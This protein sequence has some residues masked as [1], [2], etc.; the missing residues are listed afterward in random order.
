M[1]KHFQKQI[2][3]NTFFCFSPPV[4]AAT[5]IIELALLCWSLVRYRKST[6]L[7]LSVI[8][9]L[10]LA[11]FQAAEYG[12]CESISLGSSMWAKIGF[13]SITVLPVAGLHLI[14]SIAG[15][16]PK[17][18]IWFA[19]LSGLI[20][21]GLFLFGG[22]MESQVCSGNYIIFN[23]KITFGGAY[24]MYYYFWLLFGSSVALKIAKTT[25]KKT[26]QA[27]RAMVV[28]YGSFTVPATFIWFIYDG[29]SKGLPSIMCGFAVI[30][31]LILALYIIPRTAQRS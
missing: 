27:L 28:G 23:L 3:Q 4:M 13:A 31:A 5:V 6:S 14:Y 9:L 25:D 24:F 7:K 18:L 16:H 21:I 10:S 12:I 26:S 17:K 29:A 30:F 2:K 19:Y 1:K 11:V 15:R 8:I 22:I 20:W